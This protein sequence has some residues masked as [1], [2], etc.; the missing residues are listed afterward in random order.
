MIDIIRCPCAECHLCVCPSPLRRPVRDSRFLQERIFFSESGAGFLLNVDKEAHVAYFCGKLSSHTE[1]FSGKL[2]FGGQM[3]QSTKS[4][5]LDIGGCPIHILECGTGNTPAVLLLHGMKFQA[6]T[7]RALGTLDFVSGQGLHAVA[8]DMPGFGKSPACGQDRVAV[9]DGC[10]EQLGLGPVLL[11]GPSMG[12]QICLEYA[13]RYSGKLAG[14]VLIGAVGVEE[15]QN[16]LEK[17]TVP[18]LIVWGERDQVSPLANSDRLLAAL[19]EATREIYP[20]AAHPCYIEQ[21][22]RWHTSLQTFI[23]CLRK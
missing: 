16:N 19:P 7:W 5:I 22:D 15:H 20:D 17:I 12:G 14:L 10:I 23:N 13:I 8:I 3:M 2:C 6:E 11:V 21:P 4:T 18:T 9:L 1:A